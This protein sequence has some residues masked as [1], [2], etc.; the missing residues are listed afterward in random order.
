MSS[1]AFTC[2][3]M[4]PSQGFAVTQGQ[5]V[6]G[7]L[8]GPEL[9]HNFCPSCM[10]WMFTRL[11]QTDAFVNVRPSMFEDDAWFSPF[12]ETMT[13]EKL[14]WVQ[15]PAR[16]RYEGFPPMQDLDRLSAEFAATLED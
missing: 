12:I 11:E 16:Y 2:T 9:H 10:T 15:T 7:G 14:D 3:A 13:A 4:I 8:H 1:S 5:T 6:L